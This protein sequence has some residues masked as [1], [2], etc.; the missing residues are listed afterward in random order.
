MA[1]SDLYEALPGLEHFPHQITSPEDDTYNCIAWAAGDSSR[2]WWPDSQ[3]VA[4]WPPEAPR[5]ETMS[6][7]VAAFE[8][9]GFTVCESPEYE[10]GWEKVALFCRQGT[11][12]HAARQL[13]S[14]T[15]TSKLGSLED[16]EHAL[17]AIQGELY[18]Q[19]GTILER[20]QKQ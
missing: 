19:V 10:P 13:P 15:W 1:I 7:F 14:G 3:L 9:L 11:P 12:T 6:A 17:T 2:W 16:V 4:Y 20:R 18:G 5:N 8:L